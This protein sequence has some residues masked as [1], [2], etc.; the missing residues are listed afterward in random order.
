[1]VAMRK[2]GNSGLAGGRLKFVYR[3]RREAPARN[4][5]GAAAAV[6][7]AARDGYR[8]RGRVEMMMPYM[9]SLALEI[10][11]ISTDQF[12]NPY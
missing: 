2:W 11:D 12:L 8:A 5:S 3:W 4:V 6:V 7:G 9:G 10:A 1:M